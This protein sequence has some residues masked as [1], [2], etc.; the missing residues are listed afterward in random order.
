MEA[1]RDTFTRLQANTRTLPAVQLRNVAVADHEGTVSLG[2][3]R[4]SWASST[5]TNGVSGQ[6]DQEEVPCRTLD[7]LLDE[8]VLERVDLLKVDI[9]GA[10][11]EAFAAFDRWELIGTIVLE[12]HGDMLERPVSDLQA[13]LPRHEVIATPLRGLP[14]RYF[15]RADPVAC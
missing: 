1:N 8:L 15:V 5:L 13:L 12:W 7:S 14:G 9:E 10:E 11:Y 6:G 2:R 3:G 4:D